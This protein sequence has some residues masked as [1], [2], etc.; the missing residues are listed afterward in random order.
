MPFIKINNKSIHYNIN[1]SGEYLLLLHDGFYNTTSW[2]SV[3]DKLSK[4]FTVIDYDRFGYGKSDRYT[5]KFNG[6]LINLYVEEL[7]ELVE[8]L[9]LDKFH[10]CGHCLG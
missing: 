4:H 1:G 10:I 8:K 7:K 2:N 5:E 3:R 9:A 6:H